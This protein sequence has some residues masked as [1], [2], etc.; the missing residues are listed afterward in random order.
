MN[1]PALS[2]RP[3]ALVKGRGRSLDSRFCKSSSWSQCAIS[4]SLRQHMNLGVKWPPLPCPLLPWR[5]G[6]SAPYRGGFMGSK[7]ENLL[8][9]RRVI[10]FGKVAMKGEGRIEGGRWAAADNIGADPQ[11]VR[12]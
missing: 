2:P 3:S 5:R 6:G 4:R 11:P 1:L 10:A 8:A 12:L 9:A 7:R